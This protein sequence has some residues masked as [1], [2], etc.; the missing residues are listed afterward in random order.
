MIKKYLLERVT[1]LKIIHR[2]PHILP[3]LFMSIVV[4]IYIIS[5]KNKKRILLLHSY[6]PGY[7]WVRDINI[8]WSRGFLEKK[9]VQ[10]RTYYM[11]TKR[12]PSLYH[13][14]KEAK[15]VLELIQSWKPDIIV[16]FDDDAQKY[17]ATKYLNNKDVSIV[18]AG[19]NNKLSNYKYLD[20]KNVYGVR[21]H[22]QLGA[23]KIA[24]SDL[25]IFGK[26]SESLKISHLSDRSTFSKTLSNQVKNYDWFPHKLI[27]STECETYDDW[28]NAALKAN[29]EADLVFITNYHTLKR[30]FKDSEYVQ[31]LKEIATV[32]GQEVISWTLG[33]ISLPI[34]G[35]YGFLVEDGGTLSLAISPFEQ[36]DIAAQLT[37]KVMNGHLIPRPSRHLVGRHTLV[38]MRENRMTHWG[39]KLSD[40]YVSFAKATG[41]FIK[42]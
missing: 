27:S 39:W 21:E 6:H 13:K 42:D 24:L 40:I 1:S 25:K 20:A 19:V 36:G 16:A 18:Y 9:K 33:N 31:D 23:L 3:I 5:I 29:N 14:K 32:P 2:L 22:L 4:S 41:N 35:A 10:V 12:F 11:D 7:S 38:F 34:V 37:M 28:K 30:Q 8:G 26:K 15:S 17:V